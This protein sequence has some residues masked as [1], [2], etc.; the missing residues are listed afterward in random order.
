MKKKYYNDA[1][2]GNKNITASFTKYGELLRLYYPLRDYRQYSEYFYVG[3]KINDSNIIYL[4]NDINNHYNQYYTEDTNILNTEIYN[5]YFNLRTKQTDAVMLN[6]DVILR[7]YEF[8]NENTIELNINFLVHSKAVSSFN[9]MAGSLISN[10]ALIQYSHNFTSAIFSNEPIYSHQLNNVDN[11]INSGNIYDKD[12]IGMSSDAAISYDLGTIKPGEKREFL[13]IMYMQY[14]VD[15]D[16]AT[17]EQEI[18]ELRKIDIHK[19]LTKIKNTWKKF[20]EEH[21]TLKLKSD[22]SNFKNQILKIYKRTILYLPLLMNTKT[23]GVTASLE[24]DEE[25]DKS[26]RYSYCWPRDAAMIYHSMNKLNFDDNCKKFYDIFLKKTQSSNGMW[27]QRFYTDG[28]LAPCWG[29]QVDETAIV[30]WE[31]YEF[32]KI[33]NKIKGKKQTKFL[34]DNLKMFEKAIDFLEK[35]IDYILGKE[36]KDDKVKIELEKT[37]NTKNRDEIYKHPSYD[38]WEM[39][40]GVHLYS[41]SSIYGAFNAMIKIYNELN[42]YFVNNRLKQDAIIQSKKKMKE[43]MEDIKSYILKNLYDDK[44]KVLVRNT[45]DRLTDI[46]IMG[47]IVPFEVFSAKDKI[48][49]NTVEQIN[50]TLRTYLG[51]YLRFQNDTYIGGSN[52]WI[53]STC[54]MGIYY[55]KIGNEREATKCLKF[56]VNSANSLGLLAEQANSDLNEKWVIGLGWSHSM[57]IELLNILYKKNKNLKD[58]D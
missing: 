32:Y 39:N 36:E 33:E 57:F 12:Y 44:K 34:K 3:L 27:E 50:M 20:L 14:D 24:V 10:D 31:A 49:K 29:Y 9:N 4:H 23:G 5:D 46:S 18:K 22:G 37:Y 40:E 21:D 51:G 55:A 52:P 45:N 48:V 28:R 30:I 26:G 35:Y 38:L 25:R 56:V 19:E 42:S 7:K 15:K 2:I 13:L 11:N 41:L 53:I 16:I 54:W 6:K 17:A 43:E 8:K 47:A 1:F 58:I